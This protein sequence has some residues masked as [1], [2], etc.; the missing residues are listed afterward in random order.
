MDVRL[1]QHNELTTNALGK[2]TPR[3]IRSR[4]TE[5]IAH[6]ESQR[7]SSVRTSTMFGPDGGSAECAGRYATPVSTAAA[8]TTA[9]SGLI[10]LMTSP[11]IGSPKPGLQAWPPGCTRSVFLADVGGRAK[12]RRPIWPGPRSPQPVSADGGSCGRAAD[13]LRRPGHD[14]AI[15]GLEHLRERV[16]RAHVVALVADRRDPESGLRP[17]LDL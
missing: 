12:H 1:G 8:R 14:Q 4:R 17:G 16:R 6:S 7:W 2:V 9:M 5:G 3:S 10:L 11:G 15:A 13:R